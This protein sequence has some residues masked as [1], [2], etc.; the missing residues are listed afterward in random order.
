MILICSTI[1]WAGL[2]VLF[3]SGFQFLETVHP[4]TRRRLRRVHLQHVLPVAPDDAD[5]LDRDHPATPGSF[6]RR[7]RITCLTTPA[8][9]DRIFAHKFFEAIAFSSWAFLLLLGSPLMVSFGIVEG[10]RLAVLR[11]FPRVF[12]RI[13]PD[14]GRSRSGGGDLRGHLPASPPEDR[15]WHA[16][17][18]WVCW[19]SWRFLS[20]AGEIWRDSGGGAD[21]RLAGWV[22]WSRLEWSRH[23]AL[24]KP[25]DVG[26]AGSDGP[27]RLA[28]RPVLSR[29]S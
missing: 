9:P 16:R 7:R 28:N 3:F 25:L 2:F 5:L 19:Q 15:S 4:P 10:G 6:S 26:G 24:A 14:S 27:R 21:H 12:P 13:R 29:R 8:A 22:A 11:A 23:S 20:W 1:F 17:R 18:W